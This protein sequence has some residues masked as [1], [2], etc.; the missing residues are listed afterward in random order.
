MHTFAPAGTRLAYRLDR[1]DRGRDLVVGEVHGHFATL[2]QALAELEVGKHDRVFSL[3]DLVDRGPDS[4]DAKDWIAGPEPSTRFDLVLRGNHEQMMLEAL[5]E[6]PP[7]RRRMWDENA[8]SLWEMNG[9]GWWNARKPNH[10][11]RS[12]IAVLCELPFCARIDTKF[13]PVGLVHA[14]PVH[15]QWQD[16]EDGITD[17][18]T[19]GRL[20][21]VRALWSRV[22][23][24]NVQPEIGENGHE[25]LGPV[26]GVRCVLTGHTPVPEATWHENV[27]GVD[28]G[29]HIDTLTNTGD[30]HASPPP[31]RRTRRGHLAAQALPDANLIADAR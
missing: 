6:G 10:N 28:T 27:L 19:S 18:A 16:L 23:H 25:H 12:W 14:C 11:A 5:L 3:G 21:R 8:W 9:G 4:F 24:W 30:H 17:D 22:R 15:E 20:T 29:V 26:E 1:N 2:R 7:R 13:G 31:L